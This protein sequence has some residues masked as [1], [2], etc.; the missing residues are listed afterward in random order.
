MQ[1]RSSKG[2]KREAQSEPRKLREGCGSAS[3]GRIRC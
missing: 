3:L 2:R 1:R